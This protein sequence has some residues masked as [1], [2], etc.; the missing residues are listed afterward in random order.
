MNAGMEGAF[1]LRPGMARNPLYA[2]PEVVGTNLE[3][4]ADILIERHRP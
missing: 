2:E 3:E 1:I 4:V